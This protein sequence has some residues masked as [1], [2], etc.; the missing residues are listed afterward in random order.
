M[1]Q[2]DYYQILG[3]QP[4]ADARMI[5]EA[6]R[7]MAFQY[8][9]DRNEKNPAAAEKMK[10]VNEAYAVLSDAGKRREYDAMRGQFGS[11][12]HSHFRKNYSEQDIFSGS[13]VNQ[14]F[15]E[16]ARSFGLRGFD[17]LFSECCTQGAHA[18]QYGKTEAGGFF[19]GHPG[20]ARDSG[21]VRMS[22]GGVMGKMSRFFMETLTGHRS[23]RDGADMSENISVTPQLARTGG[24]YAY[25]HKKRAKRLV[26]KVPPGIRDGQR[27]RLAGMGAEGKNGGK[28]GNL[29]LNVRVKR[30]LFGKI[31]DRFAGHQ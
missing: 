3:V 16:L 24:P 17:E 18:P 1:S 22:Q 2:Q 12:A 7:K 31:R 21:A 13:D 6:Y 30:S 28:P 10:A 5:K 27:I 15:E 9:P 26:V 11:S 4:D 8:H 25:F 20:A 29:Y 19:F 23:P 14:I